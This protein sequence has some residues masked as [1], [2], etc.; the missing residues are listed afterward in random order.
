MSFLKPCI[1]FGRTLTYAQSLDAKISG[2]G[3]RPLTISCPES[4]RVTHELRR[5]HDLILVGVGTAVSDNP[6]LNARDSVGKAYS[7]EQQP[8]PVILDP[9]GR[10]ELT[11]NSKMIKN[12][13]TKTGKPPLQLVH[14]SCRGHCKTLAKVIY[15]KDKI[16]TTDNSIR[17]AWPDIFRTL[18]PFGK[19][20]MIE[21]GST[22]IQEVLQ[23]G[24]ADHI[25]ITVA[26]TFVG[27]GTGLVL[28]RPVNLAKVRS[29]IFGRDTVLVAQKK[30]AP[31]SAADRSTS[32]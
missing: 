32:L 19:S 28:D 26:P 21:G 18:E 14:E 27:P 24:V 20:I 4:F 23:H 8:T 2:P 16:E 11:N 10:L 13:R 1:P 6:G 31:M 25:I 22:I 15:I 9:S 5:R 29:G 30:S 17:F 3:S 12:V 7:L